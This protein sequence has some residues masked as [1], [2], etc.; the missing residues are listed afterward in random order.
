MA[1]RFLWMSGFHL[2]PLIGENVTINVLL[3]M[4]KETTS[5]LMLPQPSTSSTA[6][7]P[8]S[9]TFVH[10]H[11]DSNLKECTHCQIT[12]NGRDVRNVSTYTHC[13]FLSKA[14][15]AHHD[16]L[17]CNE[18]FITES[19][20]FNMSHISQPVPAKRPLASKLH[21]PSRTGR[22]ERPSIRRERERER[23]KIQKM[24]H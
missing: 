14:H 16:R 10:T 3:W 24:Y 11:T 20:V 6:I 22:R 2:S 17:I 1:T 9:Q 21:W 5:R 19:Q 13:F 15:L 4:L 7:K 12:L 8:F 23:V 18:V